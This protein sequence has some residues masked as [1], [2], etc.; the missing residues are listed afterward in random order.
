MSGQMFTI[1]LT[2]AEL[3]NAWMQAER[4]LFDTLDDIKRGRCTEVDA[5]VQRS[6]YSALCKVVYARPR[7]LP[8]EGGAS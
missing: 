1:E 3:F 2:E 8:S 7:T 6:L 4:A 5:T